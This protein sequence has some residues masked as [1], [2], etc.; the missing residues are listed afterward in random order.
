MFAGSHT[1]EKMSLM[2]DFYCSKDSYGA[3]TSEKR[4]SSQVLN[5]EPDVRDH[6]RYVK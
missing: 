6:K 3:N 4:K 5:M 1:Q 2:P